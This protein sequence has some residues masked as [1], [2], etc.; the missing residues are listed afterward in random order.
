VEVVGKMAADIPQDVLASL[1]GVHTYEE[2]GLVGLFLL[3]ERIRE[4]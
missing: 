2:N 1:S 3:L 4:D